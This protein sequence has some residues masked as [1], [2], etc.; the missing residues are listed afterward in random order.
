MADGVAVK[1]SGLPE[2]KARLQALG[3]DMEKRIVR[4]GALASGTVFKKAAVANAPTLKKP[5]K[6]RTAGALKKAI[7]A[8]R[9]RIKSKPGLE[10]VRVSVRA[11]GK[12]AKTTRDPFYWR[13]VEAGHLVRGPGQKIKGGQNRAAL[14]RSRLKASGAKF[15]EG[16]FFLREAFRGNQGAAIRAFNTR[17]EARIQKANRDLNTK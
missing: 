14:E 4:S 1:F 7:Y 5:A 9:S 13:W 17:I 12:L 10:V 8:G 16:V 2:F 3:Y 6:N 11:G 15:K